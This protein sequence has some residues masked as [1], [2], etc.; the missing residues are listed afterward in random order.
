VARRIRQIEEKKK[1]INKERKK[2]K[3]HLFGSSTRDVTVC[4]IVPRPR[5]CRDS[6]V[7]GIIFARNSQ[8][9]RGMHSIFSSGVPLQGLWITEVDYYR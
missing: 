6:D 7:V 3:N 8:C 1:K 4:I 5:R 9:K 2:E